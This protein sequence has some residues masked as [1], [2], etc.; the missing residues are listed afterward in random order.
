MASVK[1]LA[2]KGKR[3]ETGDLHWLAVHSE[4]VRPD[5]TWDIGSETVCTVELSG[6]DGKAARFFVVAGIDH[7]GKPWASITGMRPK[8]EVKKVVRASW[9][10]FGARHAA[11]IGG[12][13]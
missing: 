12:A 9:L 3:V 8:T 5:G 4:A 6:P 7:N 2:R 10:D 11:R 1:Y 13:A